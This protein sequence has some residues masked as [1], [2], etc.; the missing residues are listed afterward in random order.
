[1]ACVSNHSA[2]LAGAFFGRARGGFGVTLHEST[3]VR[4]EVDRWRRANVA[5][6]RQKTGLHMSVFGLG[7][8]LSRTTRV[9]SPAQRRKAQPDR[10]VAV[11][12]TRRDVPRKCRRPG[13]KASIPPR[14]VSLG[15]VPR[16]G[17][18]PRVNVTSSGRCPRAIAPPWRMS[19]RVSPRARST[20]FRHRGKGSAKPR[21]SR[22]SA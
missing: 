19:V 8:L 7:D 20:A 4:H 9:A 11:S 2:S 6:G 22:H 14:A 13:P 10:A 12:H 3:F 16:K 1:M 17:G 5:K 18:D 15:V 21:L